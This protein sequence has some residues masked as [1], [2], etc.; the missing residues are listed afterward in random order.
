MQQ[1]EPR[2]KL[3]RRLLFPFSGEEPLSQ[4]QMWRVV[5]SWALFFPFVLAIAA[6]PLVLAVRGPVPWPVMLF[7]F[8][9]TFLSGIVIFGFLAWFA[10]FMINRSARLIQQRKQTSGG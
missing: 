9:L 8:L 4:Q 6:M 3:M 7:L 10:V 2:F 1:L 5:I